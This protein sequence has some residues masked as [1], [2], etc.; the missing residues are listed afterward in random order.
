LNGDLADLRGMSDPRTTPESGRALLHG[1]LTEQVIG[2]F[3][4]VHRIL[5]HGY[6]ESTYAG[7]MALELADRGLAFEREAMLRVMHKGRVAGTYRPDLLVGG[8]LVVELKASRTI[9]DGDKAQVV[10]YLRATNTQVGLLLHFGPEANFFRIINSRR[11][12]DRPG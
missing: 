9:G 1:E 8:C 6:L 3:F 12:E 7:A 11:R 10:H 2:A 5:R 4:E